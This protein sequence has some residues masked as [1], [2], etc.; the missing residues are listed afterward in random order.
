[1]NC[2]ADPEWNEIAKLNGVC[3]DYMRKA[4]TREYE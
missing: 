2:S 4:L 1:M 3:F